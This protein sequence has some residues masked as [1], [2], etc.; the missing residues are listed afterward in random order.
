M[1]AQIS[2]E[3]LLKGTVGDEGANSNGYRAGEYIGSAH[4]VTETKNDG[5]EFTAVK[6]EGSGSGSNPWPLVIFAVTMMIICIV[7]PMVCIESVGLILCPEKLCQAM[8]KFMC[9]RRHHEDEE[10][11]VEAAEVKPTKKAS[12]RPCTNNAGSTRFSPCVESQP[13]SSLPAPSAPTATQIGLDDNGTVN[14]GE[15]NNVIINC[16]SIKTIV[17]ESS[18][19]TGPT[20]H[21]TVHYPPAYQFESP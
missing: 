11:D 4:S 16:D 9:R 7:G 19:L 14:S 1:G 12:P 3:S 18:K 21:P 15:K 6:F 13:L 17:F 20:F 5:N 2:T 8:C 10:D